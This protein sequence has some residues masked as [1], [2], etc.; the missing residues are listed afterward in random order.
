MK[1]EHRCPMEIY[2]YQSLNHQQLRVDRDT[3]DNNK[4]IA[5]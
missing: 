4:N 3:V 1:A 2:F 5:S